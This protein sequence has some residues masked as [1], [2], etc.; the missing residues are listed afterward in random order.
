M[1]GT[2]PLAIVTL[3][4]IPYLADRVA[5]RTFLQ[6][7]KVAAEPQSFH[8]SLTVIDLHSDTMLWPRDLLKK[9]NHGHVDLP[10][11]QAGNVSIQAMTM[12]SQVPPFLNPYM[13]PALG[14]LITPLAIGSRWPFSAWF[15]LGG[16]L[17]HQIG[18]LK[19]FEKKS[20]GTFTIITNRVELERFLLARAQNKKL[21]GTFLGIE[22]AMA[23]ENNIP[24]L[25][26]LYERGLRMLAF[27]HF[28][29]TIFAGSAHGTK[30]GG[31]SMAGRQLLEKI[32]KK[33][34]IID[35]AHVSEA[36]TLDT[37]AL[38]DR[39]VLISHTGV[40]GT[41]DTQRNI[42]DRVIRG[43]AANRGVIGVG[44]FPLAI[45]GDQ[46]KQVIDAM[47]Y[48]KKLVGSDYIALGSDYDGSVPAVVSSDQM[49][50]I[51]TALLAT[52]RFSKDEIKKIMG[53]NALRV[54]RANL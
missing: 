34:M 50:E 38:V 1:G 13:T 37:L 47:V 22:G 31:L 8:D 17:L 23:L 26:T 2:I 4:S 32:K 24:F 5:N 39:P 53:G 29:D 25:D 27:T 11:L 18:K 43:V 12:V 3:L 42:S 54:M 20:N 46:V 28:H 52:N 16:R 51:T 41:C 35:L 48:I 30:K 49:A 40:R 6:S 9:N 21:V 33:N 7:S 10:R 15:D 45:C 36:A 44:F 14:D 19:E